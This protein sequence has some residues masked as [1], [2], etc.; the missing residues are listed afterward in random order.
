MTINNKRTGW[1]RMP[2]NPETHPREVSEFTKLVG[3]LCARREI[4]I[5]QLAERLAMD[6][7]E[8]VKIVNGKL[9][10]TDAVLAGLSKA[11]DSDVRNLK[12]LAGKIKQGC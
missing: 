9:M 12:E 7:A 2:L 4:D 5:Y 11:L 1:D 10:P 8:L 3:D 6:P